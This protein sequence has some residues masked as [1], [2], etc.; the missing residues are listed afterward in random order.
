MILL[1]ADIILIDRKY[2]TDPRWPVNR[3]ALDRFSTEG[4][5][6]GMVSHAVL[7]VVGVMSYGTAT[8][9][10]PL[11]PAAIQIAYGIAIIPD[12]VLEPDYART[13][14]DEL[15]RQMSMKMSLGDAV[16]SIQIASFFPTADLL[17]TWNAK[18]FVGKLAI[19]V[20]TP[21]DWLAHQ[22][23]AGPTP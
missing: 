21:A 23:P 9:D 19:P 11:I 20:M 2:S 18:H 3:A 1:D 7:E 4:L 12:H 14:F 8:Q 5:P 22:A 15:I 10:I 13:T 6:L 16:Q 17:L